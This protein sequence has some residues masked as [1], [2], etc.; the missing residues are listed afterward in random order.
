LQ[1]PDLAFALAT[2]IQ[3]SSALPFDESRYVDLLPNIS[4]VKWIGTMERLDG[5]AVCGFKDHE[6]PDRRLTVAGDKRTGHD[7]G[8]ATRTGV[9]EEGFVGIVVRESVGQGSGPVKRVKDEK[10]QL[11]G[12]AQTP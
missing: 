5:G 1:H 7:D 3:G 8:N 4:G 2:F 12:V 6:A 11:S 9:G 10:H